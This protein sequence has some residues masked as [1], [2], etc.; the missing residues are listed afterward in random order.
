MV[1]PVVLSIAW[2]LAEMAPGLIG[3]LKGGRAGDAAQ[4]AVDIARQVTGRDDPVDALAAIKADPAKVLEFQKAIADAAVEF[5]RIAAAD[6]ASARQREV[7]AKD[8]WTPR[9]LSS[10]V[11]GGFFWVIWMVLTGRVRDLTD[12]TMVGLVGT[13]IG[14]ASAKADQVVS[15]YFGS[16]AGSE[17]K[18]VLL[19]RLMK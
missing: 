7:A 1:A 16:S 10:V 9:V 6:R 5:E 8:S 11:V 13:L 12:P 14:Y 15:Y 4:K 3:Y 18:N 17:R 19:D 2:A